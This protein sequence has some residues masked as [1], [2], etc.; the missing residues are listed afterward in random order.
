M[1]KPNFTAA[2]IGELNARVVAHNK[3]SPPNKQTRLADLKKVYSGSFHGEDPH[4]FAVGKVDERLAKIWPFNDAEHPRAD[5]GKFSAA[6]DGAPAAKA[7]RAPKITVAAPASSQFPAKPEE[8]KAL[9][10]SNAGYAASQ[11]A[12]IP[13]RR[14]EAIGNTVRTVGSVVAGVGLAALLARDKS[15]SLSQKAAG[16]AGRKAGRLAIGIPT[17]VVS[18]AIVGVAQQAH[19]I[20]TGV[21]RYGAKSSR[22]AVSASAKAVEGKMPA[23]PTTFGAKKISGKAANMGGAAGKWA[24]QRTARAAGASIRATQEFVGRNTKGP[25]SRKA[26]H[27]AVVVAAGA[28]VAVAINNSVQGSMVDPGTQ[29]AGIDTFSYRAIQ[30]YSSIEGLAEAVGEMQ[31]V[32]RAGGGEEALQKA[33]PNLGGLSGKLMS[34]WVKP[35]VF[36]AGGAVAGAASGIAAS[37]GVARMSSNTHGNPNHDERG[38]FT[39]SGNVGSHAAI[40]AAVGAATAAGAAYL[41][42]R[43]HN[44]TLMHSAAQRLMGLYDRHLTQIQGAGGIGRVRSTLASQS[45]WVEDFIDAHPKM[46]SLQEQVGRYGASSPDFYKDQI[47]ADVNKKLGELASGLQD[48]QMLAFHMVDGKRTAVWTPVKDLSNS[49]EQIAASATAFFNT[50]DQGMIKK[51]T[52]NLTAEQKTALQQWMDVRQKHIEGVD[53]L[54]A[55]HH[56]AIT[57]AEAAVKKAAETHDDAL[58]AVSQARALHSAP[59]PVEGTEAL[60]AQAEAKAK[61]TAAAFKKAENAHEALKDTGPTIASPVDRRPILQPTAQDQSALLTAR[62]RSLNGAAQRAFTAHVEKLRAAQEASA[63]AGRNRLAGAQAVIGHGYGLPKQARAAAAELAPAHTAALKLQNDLRAA[64]RVQR[65]SQAEL[66]SVNAKLKAKTP[67]DAAT[68]KTLQA[69]ADKIQADLKD[70]AATIADLTGKLDIAHTRLSEAVGPYLEAMSNPPPPGIVSRGLGMLPADLRETIKSDLDQMTMQMRDAGSRLIQNPTVAAAQK[71]AARSVKGVTSAVSGGVHSLFFEA[72]PGWN[73]S[74]RKILQ[75]G[76]LVPSGLG[77]AYETGRFAAAHAA[78]WT[79]LSDKDP[80]KYKGDIRVERRVD[81]NSGAGYVGLSMKDPTDK[82]ERVVLWGQNYQNLDA[83]GQAIP[84]GSRVSHVDRQFQNRQNNNQG[85][86][87]GSAHSGDAHNMKNEVANKINEALKNVPDQIRDRINTFQNGPVATFRSN[88][89]GDAARNAAGELFFTHMKEGYL[90]RERLP[91][92]YWNGLQALFSRQGQ[93]STANRA[94]QMLT[95]YKV[96]GG[97]ADGIKNSLFPTATGFDSAH[98]TGQEDVR[99]A[100]SA[101]ITRAMALNP[102]QGQRDNLHRAVA[103]VGRAKQLSHEQTAALHQQIGGTADRG[104]TQGARQSSSS[105]SSSYQKGAP[106]NYDKQMPSAAD[107]GW[108]ESHFHAF[109]EDHAS[110]IASRLQV[111]DADGRLTETMKML[112]LHANSVHGTDMKQSVQAVTNALRDL[113][114]SPI[115]KKHLAGK[116]G[117]AGNDL[118]ILRAVEDHAAKLKHAGQANKVV[119][120]DDFDALMKGFWDEALHPRDPAGSALGGEFASG[121]GS[122]SS[123]PSSSAAGAPSSGKRIATKL[124]S[125]SAEAAVAVAAPGRAKAA[126]PQQSSLLDA[127]T[128]GL[129]GVLGNN[130]GWNAAMRY[131]PG[132]AAIGQ[133]VA[134][135]MAPEAAAEGVAKAGLGIASRI[136]PAARFLGMTGLRYGV[137][138]GASSIGGLLVSSAAHG[139]LNLARTATGGQATGPYVSPDQSLAEGAAGA[140]GMVAGDIAGNKLASAAARAGAGQ[141]AGWAARQVAARGASALGAAGAEAA[142]ALA[143]RVLGG[144]VGAA[145]SPVGSLLLAT[146]GGYA[147]QE[148]ASAAYRG[149]QSI[150]RWFSGYPQGHAVM[151]RHINKVLS[152]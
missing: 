37:H 132:K 10:A 44:A 94:Y 64:Q 113:S 4:G 89:D 111:P 74:W 112:A 36:G 84:A 13:E 107:I 9:M 45:K 140:A 128:V 67:P 39:S 138:L 32:I 134:T 62:R 69:A 73:P 47:R 57:K 11:T 59:E 105:N 18:H 5:D 100:M 14:Y 24:A 19:D 139:A 71:F 8:H 15:G 51:A 145:G 42:V 101:E 99:D 142:G 52:A 56:D 17:A 55:G 12:V 122:A 53:Q 48:F 54:V 81:P 40:G 34:N 41:A 86:Q 3:R 149:A 29:G 88:K 115:D 150:S 49:Q 6:G 72:G 151:A 90:S 43:G 131:M 27:A 109:A 98:G 96:G 127:T 92:L 136:L 83:P 80:G 35:V 1:A 123:A 30:K 58:L 133:K 108:N 152:A 116:M 25:I 33:L 106:P 7:P 50:A 16:W 119:T 144:V 60:L 93:I 126:A 77:A 137:A 79:G 38:R 120:L 21:L 141:V 124:A 130:L 102:T 85:G 118:P 28:P 63:I 97:A 104:D 95:G 26:A 103:V 46:K 143:G 75:R 70:H 125:E 87:G 23:R 129:S 22:K 2:L 68:T 110:K 135:S 76:A 66:R 114:P 20:A 65:A 82:N 146:A 78:N 121:G 31:K 61:K 91:N 147:G 148:A 117:G